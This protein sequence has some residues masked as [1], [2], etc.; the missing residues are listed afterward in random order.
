MYVSWCTRRWIFIS[1]IFRCNSGNQSYC[2]DL[3]WSRSESLR[4]GPHA[5]AAY[6]S[7][8][9]HIP[10]SHLPVIHSSGLV[11]DEH[12]GSFGG[13][14]GVLDWQW[15]D[16]HTPPWQSLSSEQ[17]AHVGWACGSPKTVRASRGCGTV[18]TAWMDGGKEKRM[19][20]RD[21]TKRRMV[22]EWW[23]SWLKEGVAEA[24][25][26]EETVGEVIV[27]MWIMLLVLNVGFQEGTGLWWMMD[28]FVGGMLGRDGLGF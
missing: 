18:G 23:L 20:R 3:G 10:L 11:H 6:L 5:K 26:Q 17:E 19:R 12:T 4:V 13:V 27:V 24:I 21:R 1:V 28:E 16:W 9:T 7:F 8:F 22:W 15:P 2:P 25:S 14:H